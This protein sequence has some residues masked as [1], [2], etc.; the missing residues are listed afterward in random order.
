MAGMG[1][2]AGFDGL[3]AIAFP[4]NTHSTAIELVEQAAP[5]RFLEKSLRRGSGGE[6]RWRG[7]LGQR[8]RIEMASEQPMRILISPGRTKFPAVGVAGGGPGALGG[9]T[10][11]GRDVTWSGAAAVAHQGDVL[12]V[13][14]SD[15]GGNGPARE[16][17]DA[18][19]QRD[20]AEALIG[21]DIDS[22]GAE[23]GSGLL[24]PENLPDYAAT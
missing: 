7:G 6:G 21:D 12:V 8:V 22:G 20:L 10:L 3:S 13:H 11:N 1:A 15:G 19:I 24:P 18:L 14:S 2:G 17:S 4:A 16:R 5:L 23:P 9:I